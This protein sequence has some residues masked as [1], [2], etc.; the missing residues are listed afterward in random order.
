MKK[1]WFGM[2]VV[3]IAVVLAVVLLAGSAFA[4]YTFLGFTTVVTV[5]EPIT[6]EMAWYDYNEKVWSDWWEVTGGAGADELDM[7]M[8]PG[9]TQ[10]LAVRVY[11]TSLSPLTVAT[12]LSNPGG[13][14]TFGGWPNEEIPGSNGDNSLH[15]RQFGTCTV[16][17]NGDTPPG[18]YNIKVN[19]TRE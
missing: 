11:N 1:K 9:E 7:Y 5:D 8:S 6:I 15:E 12:T 16:T 10:T 13:H 3:L 14:F 2:P 4:A 18:D 19:F 17:A